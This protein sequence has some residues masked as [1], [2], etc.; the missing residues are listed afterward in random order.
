[1]ASVSLQGGSSSN[2][3]RVFWGSFIALIACAFGF[4]VRTQIIDDW[5]AEFSLGETEKGKLLAVGFWPFAFSIFA[6]SLII[7]R[8]GYGRAA[9]IGF[10]LHAS[11]TLILIFANGYDMLY[12][13]TFIFALSNG[14][15]EAYINP[16][17]A[18]MFNKQKAKWL[19]ILHA[20]W[21]GGS[22]LAGIIA[23]SMGDEVAWQ[24]KVGLTLIPTLAYGAIL[25]GCSFPQSERVIAGVSYKDMLRDFGGLGAFI[26]VFLISLQVGDIL[27]NYNVIDENTEAL[28]IAGWSII[29]GIIGGIAF[30]AYVKGLGQPIFFILCLLM[31]PLATTEL[32]IDS[33]VSELMKPE[34]IDIGLHEGWILIYT[35]AIMTVLRFCAGPIVERIN[36]I[37]LLTLSSGIALLGLVFL[38]TATAIMVLVAATVYGV[39]KTF[40]WPTMLAVVA[41]KFPRGGALTLNS[42]G[43]IGML[44]LSVG[45]L[46]LGQIQDNSIEKALVDNNKVEYLEE[47]KVGPLGAYRSVNADAV[48]AASEEVQTEI[49]GIQGDAKK[50]ALLTAAIFPA[51]MLLSYI[52]LSLYFKSQGGY[53]A[54]NLLDDNDSGDGSEAGGEVTADPPVET[55]EPEA[56]EDADDIADGGETEADD[57]DDE[58]PAAEDTA[59]EGAADEGAG[60]AADDSAE[61]S[62]D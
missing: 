24:W 20:G 42:V 7:D 52:G 1:M 16:V 53:K 54:E 26:A 2:D 56:A 15:V 32:G 57:G 17:V 21:P 5:A 30:G 31:I 18:T 25:Y 39:G 11:S 19:N 43:G 45:T 38:S 33:W 37:M 61:E 44:G 28:T 41:E 3:Q 46:F 23:I 36:P 59:D 22:V 6:F 49:E 50:G 62:D 29:P 58:A 55:A 14:T 27:K 40:F 9:F 4:V 8:I 51:I 47:E 10:L 34:M 60:E 13:G 48:A 35:M 12:W